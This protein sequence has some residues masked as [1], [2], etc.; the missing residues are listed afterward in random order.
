MT[1]DMRRRRFSIRVIGLFLRPLLRLIVKR[2]WLGLDNFPDGGF[3]FAS[4][5]IAHIDPLMVSHLLYDQDISPRFLAKSGLFEVPAL[6][7]IMRVTGQIPVYRNTGA[8]LDAFSASVEAVNRGACVIVYPE[9]TIS[10]DP[11]LWPMKGK[12]GAARIA[13]ATG[14]PLVPV[15]QWGSHEVL[16]PYTKRPHLIPRKT[17][18]FIVGAPLDI[19]DLRE[20]PL[21]AETARVAT[22]RLMIE[23]SRLLGEIRDGTPPPHPYDPAEHRRSKNDSDNSNDDSLEA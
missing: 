11:D 17:I 16:Y 4:N 2:R 10:R 1:V 18:T 14:Q 19:D 7:W 13:L 23:I 8:A 12:T 9:G 3:V 5:H 22:A 21:S 6:G 15:A 20:R